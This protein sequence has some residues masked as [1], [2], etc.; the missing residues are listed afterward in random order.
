MIAALLTPEGG[1]HVD[2]DHF[3]DRFDVTKHLQDLFAM[4]KT[5]EQPFSRGRIVGI[6]VAAH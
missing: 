6:A 2:E 1:S 5:P 3:E 4:G